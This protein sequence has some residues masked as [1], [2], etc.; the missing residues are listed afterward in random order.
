MREILPV[1]DGQA[2]AG[3]G[4]ER[5]ATKERA[6]GDFGP[7]RPTG[8]SDTANEALIVDVDGFEG[9]LDLLLNLARRQKVDLAKISILGLVEQYLDFINSATRMRLEIAADYLVMAA[10]LAYLKSRLLIPDPEPE[11]EP[12]AE[13]LAARLAFRLQRLQAMRDATERLFARPQLGHD[14]FPRGASEDRGGE[15]RIVHDD[16]LFDLL[17][18]YAERRQRSLVQTTYTVRRMPVLPLKEARDLLES[19]VGELGEWS[20]LDGL[21]LRYLA[22]PGQERTVLASSLSATLEMARDGLIEIRQDG[23]FAPIFMKAS[24]RRRP[25]ALDN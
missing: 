6:T 1:D 24:G 2:W 17:R 20:R 15:R 8:H 14:V 4:S 7:E 18:A 10:W 9:P 23:H 12:P 25:V 13:E 22:R 19:L 3:G 16:S 21:L 5:T 11:E